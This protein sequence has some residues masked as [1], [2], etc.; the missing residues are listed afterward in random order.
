VG[1][2]GQRGGERGAGA[3]RKERVLPARVARRPVVRGAVAQGGV[4]PEEE[5]APAA[6]EEEPGEDPYGGSERCVAVEPTRDRHD[7]GSAAVERERVRERDRERRV[8]VHVWEQRDPDLR[9]RTVSIRDGSGT[10][11]LLAWGGWLGGG[12]GL[13]GEPRGSEGMRLRT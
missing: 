5:G 11:T 8:R 13:R 9:C 1:R 2:G 6:N 7:S 12:G 3:A 4:A 10:A